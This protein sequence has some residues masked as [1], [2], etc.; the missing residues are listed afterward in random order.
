[1]SERRDWFALV[2]RG[3]TCP[4]CGVDVSSV[5]IADLGP[6]V[7]QEA[8][9]WDDDLAVYAGDD[10]ALRR[11]PAPGRWSALEYA[12]HVAGV[13][14]VFA[15]RVA[16]VRREYEP[17][18]GWWDHESAAIEERYAEQAVADVRGAIGDGA[19][20]LALGLP[21]IDDAAE[22]ERAGLRRGSERFRIVDLARFALHEAVH[23][24]DDAHRSWRSA[25]GGGG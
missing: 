12:A 14:R 3:G 25:G 16:T 9:R 21:R 6:L 23:H 19:V 5:A 1:M 22:W 17:D 10:G 4:E 8:R 13:L 24:R 7:L 18:L 20:A 2:T 11:S 15:A